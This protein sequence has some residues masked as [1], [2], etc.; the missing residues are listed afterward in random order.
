MQIQ[1]FSPSKP[2]I[3]QPAARPAADAPH[4]SE[5][6]DACQLGSVSAPKPCLKS[7]MKQ[8]LTT[9][10]PLGGTPVS[11]TLSQLGW[12][13][14]PSREVARHLSD[15][16]LHEDTPLGG[17]AAR[18]LELAQQDDPRVT[19]ADMV[20]AID[21]SQAAQEMQAVPQ[22]GLFGFTRLTDAKLEIQGDMLE[23]L[24]RRAD[25]E[26]S[27]GQLVDKLRQHLAHGDGA[28]LQINL[29]DH[30]GPW[31]AQSLQSM[32]ADVKEAMGGAG[33][34][35]ANAAAAIENVQS[36]FW[37]LGG[38][39]PKVSAG[40]NPEVVIYDDQG[41]QRR[42][43]EAV[44]PAQKDRVNY[45]AEYRKG[46]QIGDSVAPASGRVILST[47]GGQEIGFGKA[48]AEV[49][50]KTIEGKDLLFFAGSHYLTKG[51]PARATDLAN[52][53]AIMKFANPKATFHLQ[54][55]APKD[56]AH[57]AE[58]MNRLK[59]QV[60]S[61]S[62]NSVEV[63]AL[64]ERL[65]PNYCG[66][67]STASREVMEHPPHLLEN[68]LELKEAMGLKRLHF[69]GL[70]GDLL[71]CPTPKDPERNVLALMRARQVAAMKATNPSGEIKKA[72]QELWPVL[73]V[74]EGACLASVQKFADAVQGRYQLSDTQRD[75]VA[76]DWY[77]DDGRGSTVYFVPSRGIHDR[78]GGTVSLGDTIDSM[79][80]IYGRE[81]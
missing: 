66:P 71:V 14:A 65:N 40:L 32:G 17:L 28:S 78:T 62:L 10:I 1:G 29:D 4:S 39:P 53:L 16:G 31:L 42:A 19:A 27:C 20:R 24:Q 3:R 58:V 11:L 52:Q 44:D 41:R 81:S 38:L 74:V 47:P 48:S 55:V 2:L 46:T 79:A 13:D 9:R 54:Y 12:D 70:H 67:A 80:L 72:D 15:R 77:F 30:S 35:C 61:L 8:G 60:D 26:K 68:A 51:D 21:R 5:P 59:S 45:I 36:S 6:Q 49:L 63:P 25:P 7:L 69:H 73:P 23:Q 43:D 50:A 75:Q 57:E 56:P 34:F 76:K 18:E 33:G 22:A 64:L 37:N